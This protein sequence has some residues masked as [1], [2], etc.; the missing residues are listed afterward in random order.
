MTEII[1]ATAELVWQDDEGAAGVRFLD[2]PSY[3]RKYLLQW[4]KIQPN[5]KASA[6]HGL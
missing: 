2:M 4:L 3:A 6:A 1:H 5:D